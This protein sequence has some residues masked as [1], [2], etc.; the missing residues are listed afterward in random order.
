MWTSRPLTNYGGVYRDYPQTALAQRLPQTL[1]V[2]KPAARVQVDPKRL[3]APLPSLGVPWRKLP[4]SLGVSQ[5]PAARVQVDPKRLPA[6]LPS[7]GVPWRKLPQSL[8]VSQPPAAL[9]PVLIRAYP[10]PRFP[11]EAQLQRPAQFAPAITSP[12]N[13]PIP[14]APTVPYPWPVANRGN[15]DRQ[16]LPQGIVAVFEPPPILVDVRRWQ[17]QPGS[18]NGP[19]AVMIVATDGGGEPDAVPFAP[20]VTWPIQLYEPPFPAEVFAARA[21]VVAVFQ[22]P[23]V[24]FSPPPMWAPQWYEVPFPAAQMQPRT[25]LVVPVAVVPPPLQEPLGLWQPGTMGPA[26]FPY[27]APRIVS[28]VE[29]PLVVGVRPPYPPSLFAPKLSPAFLARLPLLAITAPLYTFAEY[30]FALT[31]DAPIAY[32][33]GLLGDEPVAYIFTRLD[34]PPGSYRSTL[35]DA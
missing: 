31:M 15:V 14:F 27:R 10:T 5:P 11:L 19:A 34:G 17:W 25:L 28:V 22:P 23:P 24:A 33:F 18:M 26:P 35:G 21:P 9:V 30:R 7:L 3:P 8:G 32:R 20:P 1:A 13:V 2:T 29:V 6:P 4:Q 16:P 12:V